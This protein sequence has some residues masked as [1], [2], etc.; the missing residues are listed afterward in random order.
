MIDIDTGMMK[1]R[2]PGGML[3]ARVKHQANH[4]YLLHLNLVWLTVF[5]VRG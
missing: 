1:I 4:L 2:E 3:L 5:M